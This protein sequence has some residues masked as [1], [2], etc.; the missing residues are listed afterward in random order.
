M[1]TIEN[2]QKEHFS[3]SY[4][5][6]IAAR[7]GWTLGL[8]TGDQHKVD[9][10]LSKKMQD[11]DGKNWILTIDFQLKCTEAPT[12]DNDE[13]VSFSLSEADFNMLSMRQGGSPMLLMVMIVP[14]NVERWFTLE[15]STDVSVKHLDVTVRH[16]AY[17]AFISDEDGN[18][19]YDDRTIRFIKGLHEFSCDSLISI[20][21]KMQQ[22]GYRES[23]LIK[24][25]GR[26]K[27]LGGMSE[28]R[29]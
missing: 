25:L 26:L 27:A 12:S 4:L 22:V 3:R 14:R 17:L 9:Q 5:A 8:W 24:E 20:E 10:T 19:L 6:A 16:C 2:W 21:K 28:I 13:F 23:A 11:V 1:T 15:K 29:S 7:C 18:Y